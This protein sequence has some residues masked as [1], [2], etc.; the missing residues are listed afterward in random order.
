MKENE[1]QV[2]TRTNLYYP[3][4]FY[5]FKCI[6]S[7]NYIIIKKIYMSWMY[8]YRYKITCTC[9]NERLFVNFLL[10]TLIYLFIED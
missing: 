1:I 3:Y 2:T 4:I 5:V 9:L 8:L 7:N 10:G 6:T